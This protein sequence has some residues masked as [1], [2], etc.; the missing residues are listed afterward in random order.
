MAVTFTQSEKQEEKTMKCE[1]DTTKPGTSLSKLGLC[2]TS[3][4]LD[5]FKISRVRNPNVHLKI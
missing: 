3:S 1:H 5:A 4:P 2:T